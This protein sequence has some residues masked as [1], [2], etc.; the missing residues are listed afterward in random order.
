MA[1]RPATESYGLTA[2]GAARTQNEDSF[3]CFPDEGV[4]LVVDGMGGAACGEV[5]AALAVEAIHEGA[6][7][8]RAEGR[9]GRELLT[10]SIERANLRILDESMRDR[11]LLGMGA[12]IA[13]SCVD[14]GAA[15]VGR[16]GDARVYRLRGE[17]LSLVTR[18]YSFIQ[19]P[20]PPYEELTPEELAEIERESRGRA[21]G[22]GSGAAVELVTEPLVEGDLHLLC[23]DGL[24]GAL[25]LEEIASIL[26]ANAPRSLERTAR[27]LVE[28]ALGRSGSESD[29]TTVVLVRIVTP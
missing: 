4:H 27:G 2:R 25:T 22:L 3:A 15:H 9:S 8:A 11:R 24:Y 6:R 18:P 14:E 7:S 19:G 26:M 29:D 28:E 20:L 12:T 5:A 10:S 23:S 17:V 16:V 13:V 21:L 1:R